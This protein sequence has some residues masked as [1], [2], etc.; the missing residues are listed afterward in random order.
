MHFRET[1]PVENGKEGRR[2]HLL[3]TTN[4]LEQAE[5]RAGEDVQSEDSQLIYV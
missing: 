2:A 5:R 3:E 4:Y 1:S